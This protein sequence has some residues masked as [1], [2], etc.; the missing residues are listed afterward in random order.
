MEEILELKKC[1]LNQKYDQALVIVE[2]LEEM[3][4][5]DKI[6]NLESFLVILLIHL[7]KI[8]V[9][10]RV[11]RSWRTSIGNSLLAIQKR[12]KLGKN[13]HY[14]KQVEW[15]EH[16]LDCQFE[17]LLTAAKE[18]F[19]GIDYQQLEKLVNFSE[20]IAISRELVDLTYSQEKREIIDIVNQKFPL[21]Y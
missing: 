18:I 1:L 19:E 17:A 21:K 11:T 3:G 13:S 10:K 2:E 14:I 5:Q 16:I 6:N 8:Q 12:N 4:R 9:E 7:I 15:T 20:I